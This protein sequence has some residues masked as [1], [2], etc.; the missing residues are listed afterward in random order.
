MSY[1]GPM[2]QGWDFNY[3][4]RLVVETNGNVLC[5]NGLG[6]VDRY[7]LNTNGT[8]MSPAGFDTQL[9]RELDGSYRERDRHGT[10]NVYSATN[11]LGIAKL[12]SINDRNGNQMTFEYNATGQL[13]NVID[14]LDRSIAYSY[15]PNGRLTNVTDFAGR[16]LSFAYDFSGNLISATSPAV[17][18]TPNGND[19]PS[20]KTTRYIYATG[21]ADARFNH[22][23]LSVT[24][25]NEVAVSGPARLVAQYDTNPLSTNADRLVSLRLGGTNA[26]GVASGGRISYTYTSFGAV[27]STDYATRVFQ[28]TATDRNGNVT[29]YQFNKLGNIVRSI[30]FT[31]GLRAGDPA[32]FTNT[33]AFNRDG[34]KIAQTNAELDSLQYTFDSANPDR[35]QQGNLLQTRALPGPRGG[36]Q[37]QIVGVNSYEPNFNFVATTTDGRGNTINFSYDSFGNRTQTTH[38]IPSIVDDFEYNEF[39]QMTAH[40]LPENDT[41]SRRRD[42]MQYYSSGSQ[43]GYLQSQTVDAGNLHLTTAYGY[44]SVG[45]IVRTV[46][47]RNNDITNVVNQLNQVV[48]GSSREVSTASGLVR[49]LRDTFYDA[50]DNVVRTDVQNRDETGALVSSNPV[51][52]TTSTFNIIDRRLGWTQEVTSASSIVTAFSY[53]SNDNP[54]LTRFGEAVAGRQT[55]NVVQMSYDERDLPWRITRAP[56]DPNQSTDQYDYDGNGNQIRVSQGLENSS[57]IETATFDGYNRLTAQTDPMGNT[58]AYRYDANGNSVTNRRDGELIDLPGDTSNVRL[59]E[60][61]YTYDA[62]NRLV[63]TDQAFFDT[64][65]G[66]DLAGGHAISQTVYTGTSQV[67]QT[68]DANGH[69]TTITHDTANRPSVVTDSKTNTVAYTYDANGRVIT[70]TEVDK[71]DLGSPDQTFVTQ[72]TYDNLD[73]LIWIVDNAGDTNRYAYDSRNNLLTHTDG[74]SNFTRDTYDGVNRRIATTRFLTADGLGSG[75]PVGTIVTGQ[76]WDDSFRLTGQIDGSSNTTAFAYDSLSR[77]IRTTFADGTT[78]RATFDVQGNKTSATDAI[79]NVVNSTFDVLNRETTRTITRAAAVAGTTSENYQ[80]DGLS[81]PTRLENNDSVVSRNYDSLSRL[82]RET[83]QI[84]PGGAD[85]TIARTYDSV[86]NQLSC[87]YPGGRVV[88]TTYD[89]LNRPQTVSDNSG[90]IANYNYFGRGRVERRDYGNG[91]RA[92]YGFDEVRRM[93]NS[94]HSVIIGGAPIDS[95]AYGWDAAHNK[96][97]FNDLLVPTLDSRSFSYDSA[98][99]LVQSATAVAGPTISYTLDAVGNRVSV[100]GGSSAGSYSMNSATPPADFQMNQYSTTS[101]DMRTNDANGNLASAGPL[102][103]IFDYR[104]QLVAA[105][106]FDGISAYTNVLSAKYDCFS[107]RLE[108]SAA[109][110]TNRYYYAG[111]QEIEEQDGTNATVAT[112][113]WMPGPG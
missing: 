54:V 104:N 22:N 11:T 96:T 29:Q 53:D 103:F 17:T 37:A 67:F 102:K 25:P 78:N 62:M 14:T 40:I 64:A 55:N 111:W 47:P 23:L 70:I 5:A 46:D 26:T 42:Q 7:T 21:F 99:R 57:R 87:N 106:R 79:G 41:A 107:R 3:N 68:I 113:I 1:D 32:G 76:N 43:N 72:K 91:T 4:R 84:N 112:C 95:R 16:A 98:N 56:G 6:R 27:G 92:D 110:T 75:T 97:A 24:A 83:Q 94:L 44:D 15:D 89:V 18:N 35:L 48:R 2:G 45:N 51:F 109:G 90:T 50:N 38:Q 10:T 28:N 73:R 60:I 100:T 81:R 63:Q 86:G 12:S 39:G 61:T 34:E 74:R 20:G 31:R 36:D 59:T 30:Q 13:T 108:K 105:L 66:T 101:F 33:F 49:Y 71:S 9:G 88:N 80:Y 58:A 52:T 8:F 85:Q 93:T 69:L 65:T 77:T 19:F 82:I